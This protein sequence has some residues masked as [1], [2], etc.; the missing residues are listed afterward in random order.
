M[1]VPRWRL[2]NGNLEVDALGCGRIAAALTKGFLSQRPVADFLSI[3]PSGCVMSSSDGNGRIVSPPVADFDS[4][5][6]PLNAG[7]IRFFEFLDRNLPPEWE[8]YVQPF[9]NGLR[10]DFVII[11]P[12]YGVAVYEVKDWDFDALHYWV[13]SDRGAH[14]PELWATDHD[15]KSFSLQRDNPLVKLRSYKEAICD[16]LPSDDGRRLYGE[17]TAGVVFS[18]AES[19]RV[20]PIVD[21]LRTR[22]E[23]RY[24]DRYPLVTVD[25][26]AGSEIGVAFPRYRRNVPALTSDR[27]LYYLRRWLPEPDFSVQQRSGVVLNARQREI[28][29]TRTG[30]GYRRIRG[31]AGTGKTLAL[32]ARAAE[33]ADRG[34]QVALLYYNITLGNYIRDMVSR[35]AGQSGSSFRRHVTFHHFHRWCKEVCTRFGLSDEYR[36]LFGRHETESVLATELPKLVREAYEK[37]RSS[38]EPC[39]AY[40]DALLVDEGQDWLPQWWDVC[41]LA[42]RNG[43]EAVLV[44]DR[45][46]DVYGN[47]AS[48]TEAAM[49]GSGFSGPWFELDR[50]YRIPREFIPVVNHYKNSFVIPTASVRP[51]PFQLRLGC[52]AR[53]VQLGDTKS[54]LEVAFAEFEGLL[55]TRMPDGVSFSDVVVQFQRERAGLSFLKKVVA[56]REF[57][58]FRFL[59][60]YQVGEGVDAFYDSQARKLQFF[61]GDSRVKM[62]TIHGLKGWEARVTMVVIESCRDPEEFSA[63][64][65][66]LTRLLDHPDGWTLVVV[67]S[68]PELADYGSTWA[69]FGEFANL[70]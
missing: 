50:V 35:H 33:V 21:A 68:A 26:L 47:A 37:D 43:G 2:E 12:G 64:Y 25:D 67:C 42:L 18:S 66:A 4:L 44:G 1:V 60:T 15:G 61:M 51:D 10:P 57:R 41:R 22:E 5:R 52:T 11:R 40:Y 55:H 36:S 7:E 24:L 62:T 69:D 23:A 29:T 38:A 31:H 56:T 9:L 32:A 39:L 3:S 14:M 70:R 13:R 34:G 65:T 20:A 54:V 6:T 58:G 19:S 17:V 27:A 46:Q 30:T 8:I 16:F 45:A 53:W 48:W 59:H 49:S 28:A 63:V